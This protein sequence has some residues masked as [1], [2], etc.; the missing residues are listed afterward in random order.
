MAEIGKTV[1]DFGWIAA[2]STEVDVNGVQL[3]TTNPPAISSESRWMEAAVPGTVLGTLVKN[4]AIPD[5]FYGLENEA[6]TD[7]ADSGRDYYTF[8]F[9]TK[10]QCQ[11]LLNQYVH[12]NF[13]AINYSA[14][15][16]VNGHK[17]EL[18]KGM[19]RRHTLDVTDILHPESNLLALIVHPPDHPGTIPPE[20]GQGGD[21][22]IGKDVAAQ[23]VQGWDWIC[24]IRDRNTGIWDEVSISVTGVR[25]VGL[26]CFP[27]MISINILHGTF[28]VIFLLNVINCFYCSL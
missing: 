25:L 3:T 5:P 6:I 12:L 24:P 13:R 8:W 18:P 10:F 14:Q 28:I 22:E 11:R 27:E 9:F 4:K 2:R 23:Y 21:H 19:F 20:G 17:T 26:H 1:L 15:V 16:F 7:I